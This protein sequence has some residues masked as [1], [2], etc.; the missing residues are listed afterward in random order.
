[1][2]SLADETASQVRVDRND[3]SGGPRPGNVA[4]LAFGLGAVLVYFVLAA[5]YESWRLPLAVIL[6][7]P[8]C[9]LAWL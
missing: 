4:M 5:K 9:M 1:M 6:V 8:L 2:T 3:L 7:V